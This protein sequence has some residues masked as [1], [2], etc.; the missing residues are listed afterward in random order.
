MSSKSKSEAKAEAKA[1]ASSEA[2]SYSSSSSCNETAPG[3]SRCDSGSMSFG[4][5]TRNNIPI[6]P[7]GLF[8]I[9]FEYEGKKY[10]IDIPNKEVMPAILAKANEL[11]PLMIDHI[12]KGMGDRIVTRR[13]KEKSKSKSKTRSKAKAIK[14]PKLL[15]QI[16]KDLIEE[17]R[18]DVLY[19][20]MFIAERKNSTYHYY[21][22]SNKVKSQIEFGTKHFMIEKK[23]TDLMGKAPDRIYLTGEFRVTPGKLEYNFMS[24]T[25]MVPKFTDLKSKGIDTRSIEERF[26]NALTE[27][28]SK[29]E[30]VRTE[31]RTF[32]PT[33][34]IVT[35]KEWIY[36]QN[37]FGPYLNPIEKFTWGHD[38]G[39]TQGQFRRMQEEE[40]RKQQERA[41]KMLSG[42]SAFLRMIS[43]KPE[44]KKPEDKKPEGP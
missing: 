13:R 23:Y 34:K 4:E 2:S 11:S 10:E 7:Y 41:N 43:K 3:L 15:K 24:G 22:L 26:K 8:M 1:E 44:D 16:E 25:Y 40:K 42:N 12:A 14:A 33:N 29:M 5:E 37:L 20:W 32:I 9:A 31:E 28:F 27:Y 30:V 17:L 21:L 19:T 38:D 35:E 18:G 36:I 6:N 39:I